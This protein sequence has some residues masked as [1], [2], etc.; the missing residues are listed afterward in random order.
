NLKPSASIRPGI[1]HQLLCLEGVKIIV[2]A[3]ILFSPPRRTV[4]AGNK[5][6]PA[7]IGPRPFDAHR[8]ACVP[9][10]FLLTLNTWILFTT[11]I[12]RYDLVR[13]VWHPGIRHI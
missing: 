9:Q 2:P 12:H 13:T 3:S 6:H 8:N 4:R 10:L 11:E 1:E 5:S 7:P